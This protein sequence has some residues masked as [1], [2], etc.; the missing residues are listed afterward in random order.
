MVLA[1]VLAAQG[2]ASE[3]P[4]R[5][6][7]AIAADLASARAAFSDTLDRSDQREDAPAMRALAETV[8]PLLIE[9]WRLPLVHA[10]A[11]ELMQATAGEAE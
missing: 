4:G 8:A 3:R 6:V 5:D 11:V 1:Q 2:E 9:A 7:S 10:Q